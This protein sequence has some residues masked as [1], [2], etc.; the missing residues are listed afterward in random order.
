MWNP[1]KK[2]GKLLS[3]ASH[4]NSLMAKRPKKAEKQISVLLYSSANDHS[5]TAE[6]RYKIVEKLDLKTCD[7]A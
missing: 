4:T 2:E 6:K 1:Q 3:D 7:K 5:G